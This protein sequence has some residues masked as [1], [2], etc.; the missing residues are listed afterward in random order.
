MLNTE[1]FRLHMLQAEEIFKGA[2]VLSVP[3]LSRRTGIDVRAIR[4]ACEPSVLGVSKTKYAYALTLN[5]FAK[6]R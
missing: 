6:K 5:K 1:L 3:E 4:K 2:Q